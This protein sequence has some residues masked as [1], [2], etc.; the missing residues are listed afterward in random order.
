MKTNG[1]KKQ[2][3]LVLNL[4]LQNNFQGFPFA[5]N[6]Q[7]Y[8]PLLDKQETV[9]M[10]C[11]LIHQRRKKQDLKDSNVEDVVDRLAELERAQTQKEN[12]IWSEMCELQNDAVNAKRVGN[13]EKARYAVKRYLKLKED[14]KRLLQKLG[15]LTSLREMLVNAYSNAVSANLVANSNATLEGL[16]KAMPENLDDL[17]DR[18]RDNLDVVEETNQ[19]LAESVVEMD[20]IDTVLDD[21]ISKRDDEEDA[22]LGPLP[23]VPQK[24][25]KTNATLSLLA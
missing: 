7:Q 21:L 25:E 12:Q 3:E 20:D 22:K 13:L 15:N 11:G 4:K 1:W 16:I 2:K 17:M 18:L 23:S 19:T 10:C 14:Q 6:M 9:S 5:K 8:S 24:G